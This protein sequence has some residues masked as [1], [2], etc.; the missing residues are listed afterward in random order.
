[1]N[2]TPRLA[3]IDQLKKEYEKLRKECQNYADSKNIPDLL[4]S[5]RPYLRLLIKREKAY[6]LYKEAELPEMEFKRLYAPVID[7]RLRRYKA[8]LSGHI[9]VGVPW[10]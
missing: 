5:D 10:I 9:G 3:K 4:E 7:H 1:M 8:L 6:Y 2:N